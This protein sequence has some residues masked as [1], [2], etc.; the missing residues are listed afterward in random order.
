MWSQVKVCRE[1]LKWDEVRE[2][3]LPETQK[4]YQALVKFGLWAR[5]PRRDS[6][7]V[8]CFYYSKPPICRKHFTGTGN[9]QTSWAF[10]AETALQLELSYL[11][12][13]ET[14]GFLIPKP[15][16]LSSW[17]SVKKAMVTGKKF[18]TREM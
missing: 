6:T 9:S 11:S 15:Q 12:P 3:T 2:S 13:K 17:L 7:S 18:F 14:V 16:S 1:V 10:S 5:R 4:K 8:V